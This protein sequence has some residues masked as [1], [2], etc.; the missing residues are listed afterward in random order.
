[1]GGPAALGTHPASLSS[2][3]GKQEA[4]ISA[5]RVQGPAHSSEGARQ[6]ITQ[7]AGPGQGTQLGP[8]HLFAK[9]CI[10]PLKTLCQGW[11][12]VEVLLWDPGELVPCP[13]GVRG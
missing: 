8:L 6:I 11:V 13:L 5:L 2:G 12:S 4:W 7:P 9:L 1:M 3:A 10:Y